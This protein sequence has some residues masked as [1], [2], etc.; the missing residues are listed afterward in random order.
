MLLG[1]EGEESMEY[2]LSGLSIAIV[3]ATYVLIMDAFF[4][5]KMGSRQMMW[6]WLLWWVIYFL[7][8]NMNTSVVSVVK[9]IE[10]FC[11][12]FALSFFFYKCKMRYRVVVVVSLYA[13]FLASSALVAFLFMRSF[14][15]TMEEFIENRPLYVAAFLV[16]YFVPLIFAIPTKRLH[17]PVAIQGYQHDS[18]LRVLFFPA[19]SLVVIYLLLKTPPTNS[20]ALAAWI[21]SLV[22]IVILDV[23][24]MVMNERHIESFLIHEQVLA[25]NERAT[26][27]DKNIQALSSAYSAQRKLTHD[28]KRHLT[29]LEGLIEAGHSE[30]ALNYIRQI[31]K[32]QST[33]TLIV[34]SH[35]PA[36]DAILNQ[37][38]YEAQ[39]GSIDIHLDIN[40][41]SEVSINEIDLVV[42]FGNLLDN[43]I[44]ACLKL[45]SASK[46]WI[47]VKAVH[48]R[49]NR[50]LFA[51][52]HNSSH[53]VSVKNDQIATTKENPS[54]HGFGIPNILAILKKYKAEYTMVYSAEEKSFLFAIDWP[55]SNI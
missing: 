27:Q 49:E 51:S 39:K 8:I 44:E 30:Q 37:K 48:D 11:F 1:M 42:V 23:V 10:D 24:M 9:T 40:D 14:K 7:V 19:L 41:L 35:N 52:V 53:P 43:A 5:K 12:L 2:I 16:S 15:V 47:V 31:K 4:V 34:N 18:L 36:M 17:K 45:E 54:L 20:T 50:M 46:R 29:S 26:T 13:I 25:A 38:I 28:F 32:A 6:R 21:F 55:E 3:G 22:L 33:Q